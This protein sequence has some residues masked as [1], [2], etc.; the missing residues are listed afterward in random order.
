MLWWH[1]EAEYSLLQ[2]VEQ[3]ENTV[4]CVCLKVLVFDI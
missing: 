4:S 1:Q 3:G 2:I